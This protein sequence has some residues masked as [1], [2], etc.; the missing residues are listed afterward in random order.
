MGW[1][2][3]AKDAAED[4]RRGGCDADSSVD[5]TFRT[6]EKQAECADSQLREKQIR[7]RKSK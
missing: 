5:R 7:E 3:S 2:S 4:T 1:F 6:Y